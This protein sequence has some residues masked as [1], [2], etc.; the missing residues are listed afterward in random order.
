LTCGSGAAEMCAT[1]AWVASAKTT[2]ENAN[3]TFDFTNSSIRNLI[4]SGQ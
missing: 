1:G 3:V 4:E 2:T